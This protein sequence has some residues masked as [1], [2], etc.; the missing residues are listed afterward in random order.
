MTAGAEAIPA[1]VQEKLAALGLTHITPRPD[2]PH[3]IRVLRAMS[4]SGPVIVTAMTSP[5]RSAAGAWHRAEQQAHR[6]A[7]TEGCL[8][9]RPAMRYA[10]DTI[11]VFDHLEGAPLS[12]DRYA[13]ELQAA[14]VIRVLDQLEALY[15]WKPDSLPTDTP[16]VERQLAKFRAAGLLTPA[17]DAAVRVFLNNKPALRPEL[18]TV[19]TGL[20]ASADNVWV[21][22]LQRLA[23]RPAGYDWAQL[24][25][26]W[27]PAN[28]WLGRELLQ[29][30]E[31]HGVAGTYTANFMLAA[32]REWLH[33]RNRPFDHRMIRVAADN[34]DLARTL[35]RR[36][37]DTTH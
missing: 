10:D 24:Q 31:H 1:P 7:A 20:R 34:V 11:T 21:S 13:P 32:A 25:L 12:A 35:L 4:T 15:S 3:G 16:E 6:T 2:G 28:P 27:G 18:G 23:W 22:D 9:N 14:T 37:Y 33:I 26:R 29:R 8:I 30:A 17:T 5:P 36:I 19:H